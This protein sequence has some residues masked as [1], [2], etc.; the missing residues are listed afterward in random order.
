MTATS[1]RRGLYGVL[2]GGMVAAGGWTLIPAAHSAPDPCSSANQ[3]QILSNISQQVSNY[4]VNHPATNQALT[5][6]S[7]Q[8]AGEA[9]ANFEGY[10][11]DHPA[12]ANDLR[13]IQQPLLDNQNQC[14][15]QV[16]ATDTFGAF[17]RI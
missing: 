3:A 15:R 8:P 4:L 9:N 11:N 10:F 5:D 16:N 2:A 12:E 6:I 13:N 1:V 14:G 17:Q 7:R